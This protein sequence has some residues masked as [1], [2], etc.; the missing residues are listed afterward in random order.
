MNKLEAV[1]K[2]TH[3]TRLASAGAKVSRMC[4]LERDG[5]CRQLVFKPALCIR[6]RCTKKH[7]PPG[8]SILLNGG[9]GRLG[10]V[11]VELLNNHAACIGSTSVLVECLRG[12]S[13]RDG[14]ND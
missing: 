6:T 2:T 8:V 14:A 12:L 13:R 5:A 7:A 3:C 1:T 11:V 4:D 9:T 10:R